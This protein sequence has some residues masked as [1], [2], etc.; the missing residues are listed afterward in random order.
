MK[1]LDENPEKRHKLV[2][3][4]QM[5]WLKGVRK[6]L[7]IY[8]LVNDALK[9]HNIEAE[10]VMEQDETVNRKTAVKSLF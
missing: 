7:F 3:S 10:L 4:L 1:Y 5:K 9:R 2:M 6:G 8:D